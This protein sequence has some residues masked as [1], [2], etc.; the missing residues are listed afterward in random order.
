MASTD[1]TN[2]DARISHI[3]NP[4]RPVALFGVAVTGVV[5]TAF[6]GALTNSINGYVSPHYFVTVLRWGNVEDVWRASVAQ[7]VF[8]G[9]LFGLFFSLVFT[10]GVGFITRAACTYGFALRYIAGV[11]AG[12]FASWL[13]GGTA[14]MLLATLSPEFYRSAFIGVPREFDAML[15]YA[16]VGGSIWGVQLGGLV[17]VALGLVVLRANWR[18]Q[19]EGRLVPIGVEERTLREPAGDSPTVRSSDVRPGESF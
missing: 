3:E 10:F 5:A 18:R 15:A 9:L 6:L 12:A 13:I 7:G 1:E 14:A 16:W 4:I 11:I 17:C 8:E 19:S 2:A